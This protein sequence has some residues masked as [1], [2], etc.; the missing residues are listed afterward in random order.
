M[1]V[2]IANVY[3]RLRCPPPSLYGRAVFLLAAAGGRTLFCSGSIMV[4]RTPLF[5]V[6]LL[7]M[8]PAGQGHHKK[9]CKKKPQSVV[10]LVLGSSFSCFKNLKQYMYKHASTP[11]DPFCP[12]AET[13][14]FHEI[15]RAVLWFLELED[16]ASTLGL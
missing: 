8:L 3:Y 5:C 9:T 2:G 1:R 16:D 15:S 10:V 11:R 13:S 7:E 6:A 12:P 14:F 4:Q